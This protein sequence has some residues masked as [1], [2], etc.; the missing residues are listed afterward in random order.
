M[1]ERRTDTRARIQAAALELFAEHG[2]DKTSLRE[3]AER[4]GLTKAALYYHFNSKEDIAVSLLESLIDD[5]DAIIAWF[6]EQPRTP[7]TRQ[8]LVERYARLMHER[9]PG[10]RRLIQDVRGMMRE[11]PVADRLVQRM[12]LMAGLLTDPDAPALVRLKSVVALMS[13]NAATFALQGTDT[14]PEE[15]HAA[16]VTLALELISG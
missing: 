11:L 8:E 1:G 3:L 9:P 2:Y 4:L 7:Q 14:T 5:I 15:R 12:R 6:R 16:G 10:M 13:I